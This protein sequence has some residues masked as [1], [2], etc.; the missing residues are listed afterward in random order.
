MPR[1]SYN[2]AS[3]RKLL[4]W[5]QY[6]SF[7]LS[8]IIM[9]SGD[10]FCFVHHTLELGRKGIW[11]GRRMCFLPKEKEKKEIDDIRFIN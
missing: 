6:R 3:R 5:G 10:R 4:Y 1:T 7:G 8:K 2:F 9:S 11:G